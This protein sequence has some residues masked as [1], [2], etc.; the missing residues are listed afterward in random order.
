MIVYDIVKVFV[1]VQVAGRIQK[2]GSDVCLL[3]F[4]FLSHESS[5]SGT[6]DTHKKDLN[7][8]ALL[9]VNTVKKQCVQSTT[10]TLVFKFFLFYQNTAMKMSKLFLQ[11]VLSGD[12]CNER[13]FYI[14]SLLRQAKLYSTRILCYSMFLLV[15]LVVSSTKWITVGESADFGDS[16]ECSTLGHF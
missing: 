3:L 12:Q 15:Q 7:R 16:L 13:M 10:K 1:S 11:T 14:C 2:P 8:D 4:S 6:C 5:Q 9:H